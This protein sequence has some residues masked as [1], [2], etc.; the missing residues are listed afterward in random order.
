MQPL[1]VS[2]NI[3]ITI[4]LNSV[5]CIKTQAIYS[6]FEIARRQ[7]KREQKQNKVLSERKMKLLVIQC[8]IAQLYTNCT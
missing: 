1:K 7:R 5:K 2:E 3:R 4:Y 8:E 6:T